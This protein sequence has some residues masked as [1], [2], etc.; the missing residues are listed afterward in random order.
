MSVLLGGKGS[1][2]LPGTSLGEAAVAL[3]LE[4][5]SRLFVL[6]F[7]TALSI[8]SISAPLHPLYSTCWSATLVQKMMEVS[9]DLHCVTWHLWGGAIM[10]IQDKCCSMDR[11]GNRFHQHSHRRFWMPG[12][13]SVYWQNHII[14][15]LWTFQDSVILH[16]VWLEP[17]W[18]LLP[19]QQRCR[20]HIV[21]L[22][23]HS[24]M[25]AVGYDNHMEMVWKWKIT[26]IVTRA[27][28]NATAALSLW[29]WAKCFLTVNIRKETE[30]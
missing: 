15:N 4:Q 29:K 13:F 17:G 8:T 19:K 3:F 26:P 14:S 27:P 24:D 23:N 20:S 9:D 28:K 18:R 11:L 22:L 7:S 30:Y 16:N 2:V 12:P 25:V 1:T 6:F 10:V 21:F 5:N